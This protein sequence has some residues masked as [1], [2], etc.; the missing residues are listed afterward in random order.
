M[1]RLKPIPFNDLKLNFN[2]KFK[3][4]N[5]Q[6]KK[7]YLAQLKDLRLKQKAELHNRLRE[8][9]Q[10]GQN[11]FLFK[12][13]NNMIDFNGKKV[14]QINS[15]FNDEHIQ[16][17]KFLIINNLKYPSVN[18]FKNT[19]LNKVWKDDETGEINFWTKNF[20]LKLL[21]KKKIIII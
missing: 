20:Y 19:F 4:M 8:F 9:R 14:F 13:T 11:L 16:T 3:Q 15:E 1:K 10:D 17:A 18:Y 7:N 2:I 5:G 21:Y 6:E 12:I